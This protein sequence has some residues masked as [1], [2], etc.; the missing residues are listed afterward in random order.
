MRQVTW[1]L[2]GPH[3]CSQE[4][5]EQGKGDLFVALLCLH[6]LLSPA[7]SISEEQSQCNTAASTGRKLSVLGGGG[8]GLL[9]ARLPR[10]A[11][12]SPLSSFRLVCATEQD[13]SRKPEDGFIAVSKLRSC[14][15]CL[16]RLI[17]VSLLGL[18]RLSQ[19]VA[20]SGAKRHTVEKTG[21]K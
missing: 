2:P 5:T 16:R 12:H 17:A 10:T 9:F 19:N 11:Y 21:R 4:G 1:Q 6:H 7:G 3:Q 8:W 20:L 14:V 13:S 15:A 18:L